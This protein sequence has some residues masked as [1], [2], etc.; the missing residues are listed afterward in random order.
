MRRTSASGLLVLSLATA[1]GAAD[2]ASRTNVLLIT[3]DTLRADHLGIYGY[4][5]PTS[6]R[7]DA[8]A[9]SAVVFDSA[10]AS[11]SWTL[12][13]LASLL[14]SHYTSTHGCW[15]FVSTLDPSFQT[16]AEILCAAGYDTAAV[17]SHAFLGRGF[18]LSQGFVHY[19]DDLVHSMVKSHQAISSPGVSER[20]I[21][22]LQ[23]KAALPGEAPFFL[24]L[25]YF[26][27]HEEYLAHEGF[28]E[29]FGLQAEVDLYDGEI[30]FTDHHIGRVLDALDELQLADETL[31]VFTTD[32]GEEFLDH[33]ETRHGHTL[34]GELVHTPLLVRAPGIGPRRCDQVVRSI[35]VLPTVLDL[36]DIAPPLAQRGVSLAPLLLGGSTPQLA[37]LAEL[38]RDPSNDMASLLH[39]PWK[40][41]VDRAADEVSLYHVIDD[42]QESTLR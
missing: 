3:V 35:D 9:E 6:P 15:E 16:W 17:A 37:A 32:H 29:T 21:R 39:R 24:W 5:R 4:D 14:T 30:A 22:F 34:F 2:P 27:P 25:H 31:V 33:G 19:D 28:S 18:G 20:G 23:N 36:L 8:W 10:Q 38:G 12:P 26:D 40:L 13:G 1:C 11:S 41:V 42:P 7:L